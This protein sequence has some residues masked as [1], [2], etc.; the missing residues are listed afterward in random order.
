[1][2]LKLDFISKQIESLAQA[3]VAKSPTQD[4]FLRQA[5]AYL[6]SINADALRQ[7]LEWQRRQQDRFPWLVAIPYGSLSEVIPAPPTP[8]NFSVIGVDASSMPPDRHSSVRFYVLNIGY[9]FLTYGQHSNAILDAN[10]R[11]CFL[12][13]DLY[14]FPEKRDVPIEGT[15]F[16]ARMELECLDALQEVIH[17]PPSLPTAALRDGPLILWALQNESQTVQEKLLHGFLA[18]MAC[19]RE[20]GIPLAGYISYTDSRDVANS[21]RVWICKERPNECEH[22]SSS[23]RDLCLA[24][25][26][27]RDRDLFN[28][29]ATGERSALFGSSSQ[30]LERYGEHRVDFFYLNV[31]GEIVRVEVPHWVSTDAALLDLLH[32]I[33]YDQCQR[34]PGF[35]P[36]PPAL[37]EAHEQAVIT[38]AERRLIEEM[39][40]RALGLHGQLVT[41][42]AKDDSKRRR[43]V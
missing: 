40:E 38:T 17:S 43:G 29:L 22:C 15:L 19:L 12:D 24:L 6:R 32:A 8:T 31:G 35:P 27:I 3:T 1:M 33:L 16:N 25:A 30:I 11:F 41:R 10:S 28:F 5:Q 20:E 14:L 26:K 36:Y 9:A 18:A 42:S 2:P 4:Q 23:E 34:S 37:L 21:L 39:V 13:E 7:R